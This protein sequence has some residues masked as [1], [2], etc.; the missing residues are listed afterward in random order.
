M[1]MIMTPNA[2]AIKICQNSRHNT[3]TVKHD[4]MA[5]R[6]SG[7]NHLTILIQHSPPP[8]RANVCDLRFMIECR[9]VESE[10][11]PKKLSQ[12]HTHAPS[13][14]PAY[15]FVLSERAKVQMQ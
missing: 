8:C 11:D 5:K 4:L 12:S 1:I 3:Q 15:C 10:V 13:K 14:K 9:S 6:E 2:M 7:F